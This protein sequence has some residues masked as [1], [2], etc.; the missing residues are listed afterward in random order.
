MSQREPR[1]IPASVRAR[2]LNE[3]K[4][5]GDSYDQ[6]LQ[7]FAIERFL[8]R[9]SQTEWADR[10]I[11]KGAIMLR[12]WGTPLGRPTRDID[13]LGNIDNSPE[14][15]ERAVRECLAV[16]YF[17]DGLA[18]DSE[19]ET[20]E[21]NVMDR[22]PGIR[23]VVRGNLDGGTFKLQLDIGIDDAVVPDPEW[24]DY[25]TMLDLEAPR[26]LA[27]QPV[28]ALAEKFE[29]IVS[30]GLTNSRLRDYYDLW[31]LPTLHTYEGAGVA[32]AVE[33]T[34]RHR[35]TAIPAEV[36]SGLA[37][38]FFGT[39]ANQAAWRSFLANRRVEAPS[40]LSDV[41]EAIV[42]FMMPVAVA[43]AGG[44]PYSSTW[45]PSSGWSG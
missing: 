2:L 19:I 33:A 34:F 3:A 10:L 22:Y 9:L 12:A 18:F 23:V 20:A 13:F 14:A 21:I 1:N 31:L 11:V 24:V 35:G 16:E 44:S 29:T 8:Y 7:Y 32:A 38:A 6:V 41:C 28:T 42:T 43:A 25:P 15:G 5:S 39:P 4:A 37:N 40:D 45:D 30:R 36:P 26:V 17:D 27:Y